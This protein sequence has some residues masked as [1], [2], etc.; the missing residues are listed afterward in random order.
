M[1]SL[2]A[3]GASLATLCQAVA[4][5]L[6]GSV[7][8]ARRGRPGDQPGAAAGY[9]GTGSATYA[10]QHRTQRRTGAGVGSSRRNGTLGARLSGDGE[11]CRVMAVIGGD[12]VLGSTVLFHRAGLDDIAVRTF[13]R[14]SSV[15]GIV[16]LSQ[17][18]M[19][20]TKSRGA[21]DAAA[22]AGVTAAGRAGAD[23]EPGRAHGVDLAQPLSLMLIEMDGP[24]AGYAARRFRTL[25]AARERAGRRDRRRA[26]R[27][28]GATRAIDVRQTI[29]SW[30]RLEAAPS[31]GRAVASGGGAGRIPRSMRRSSAR[32]RC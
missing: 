25:D 30:A 16:L 32:C 26:R 27:L 6:G 1:T 23:G 28:C 2:L 4:Q 17:E 15:I 3:K 18:R 11:S 31:I 8:G 14:S 10:P 24:S 20:A 9:T 19:E 5:L 22:V 7:L 21:V 13:E 12:D 29:S